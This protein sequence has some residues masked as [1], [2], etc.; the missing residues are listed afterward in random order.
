M[1]ILIS[2]GA[3]FI[4]SHVS[5]KALGMGHDV[6]VVDNLSHGRRENVPEAA[7]FILGDILEP[8]AWIDRVQHT[9]AVIHLAA[10]I[11]VPASEVDPLHDLKMNLEGTVQMLL[12][13]KIL[14]ATQFRTASSAAV[15][16]NVDALPLDEGAAALPI[17]FYG[18]SKFT[19][20]QYVFHFAELHGMDAVVF[21]LANV[22]GPRQK[23]GGEGG[24]VAVFC[25]ALAQGQRPVI[26]G[27]GRQTRDFVYAGDVAQAFLHRLENPGPRTLYNVSTETRTSVLTLFE[28]LAA[29]AGQ[30]ADAFSAAKARA[31]DI[32]DSV[33]SQRKARL[34]GLHPQV[35]LG[36]GLAATW[37]YFRKLPG[38]Q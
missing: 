32:A 22:Y 4:G 23:T 31:G 36:Q 10:Q 9:D 28:Q 33:L 37:E 2:G 1:R 21:R 38:A 16:G 34:W 13:A 5:E 24:V 27:D 17:S 30:P 6:T 14:G 12:A 19:A 25:E 26:H 7:H 29:L 35:P 18:W 3:G 8:Q 15:Y 20:E 11:S